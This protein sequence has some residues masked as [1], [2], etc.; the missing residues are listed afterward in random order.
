MGTRERLDEGETETASRLSGASACA[1]GEPLERLADEL[2]REPGPSSVT[3]SS[4]ISSRRS[5]L[6]VIVPSP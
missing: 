1:A 5:A 4:I 2:V 6:R 3:C